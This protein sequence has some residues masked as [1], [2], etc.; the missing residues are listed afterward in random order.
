[1]PEHRDPIEDDDEPVFINR[2][3]TPW[4]I[5]RRR[6]LRERFWYWRMTHP[7]ATW[8]LGILA[9]LVLSWL[10]IPADVDFDVTTFRV[11]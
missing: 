9:F 3:P 6:T 7:V 5:V 1:M 11:R 2:G 4:P 8:V 10:L